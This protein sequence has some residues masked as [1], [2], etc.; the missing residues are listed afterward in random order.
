[1]RSIEAAAVPAAQRSGRQLK[2]GELKSDR[3]LFPLLFSFSSF[4]VLHIRSVEPTT[5]GAE[6]LGEL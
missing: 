1:L 4:S 5:P 6:M 3:I 2:E